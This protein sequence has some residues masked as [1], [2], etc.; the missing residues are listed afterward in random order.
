MAWRLEDPQG[1]EAAKI[2]YDIVPFTRGR[3]LD[4]GAGAFKA[5]PHFISVDNMHHAQEFGWNYKPDIVIEDACKLDAFASQ[6]MDFVFSS[7]TLEHIQDAEKALR[8][9]WRVLK[10][11]GYL[12]LYLPDD[13]LYPKCGTEGANPDHK[14]DLNRDKVIEWMKGVGGWNLIVDELR[15]ADNGPGEQGNEYSFYQVYRKRT[16]KIHEYGYQKGRPEK[17]VCV[18]RYGGFGD[19]IQASTVF[20]Y[21]KREGYHVAVMTTPRGQDMLRANPYVDEF[22]IQDREQVPNN[23]LWMYWHVWQAKFTE[24]V[25]LSESVEGSLLA[26]PG[27]TLYAWGHEARHW[28]LNRNYLEVTHKIAAIPYSEPFE[29]HFFP[30]ETER[31]WAKAINKTINPKKKPVIVW[32]LAGSSVHKTWP[33]LDQ[34][35][36]RLML[37][38]ECVVVLVGDEMCQILEHGWENEKRVI[39]ASGVW[40]I[41][42][43]ITYAQTQADLVIGTETGLLNAVGM[44]DVAKIVL[45]SHS[46]PENL[47]KHWTNTKALLPPPEIECYPCHMMHYGFDHCHRHEES[48]TAM[49]QAMISPDQMWGAIMDWQKL[50]EAKEAG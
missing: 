10:P 8:E 17:S 9:W 41:R 21:Y 48:G 37:H 25:N 22:I 7:H 43:A 35:L 2:K 20:P 6:S 44:E 49:C 50:R 23:E 30:T 1:N 45:L 34:V 33:W 24:F 29:A 46:S 36:A 27:R 18:V 4:I 47:T 26:L 39:R 12:V 14:H 19:M 28:M 40:D 38:T 16:D 42:E 11:G 5:F 31:T 13:S 32:S 15:D 3:G